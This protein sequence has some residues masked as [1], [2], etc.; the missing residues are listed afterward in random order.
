MYTDYEIRMA[1]AALL[2]MKD[3]TQ[4]R[5]AVLH[6]MG[7]LK[8]ECYTMLR[9]LTDDLKL[10][11]KG[12]DSYSLT[13]EGR[14]AVK[15]GFKAYVEQ[16]DKPQKVENVETSPWYRVSR[17]EIV[18]NTISAVIASIV[19]LLLTWLFRGFEG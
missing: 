1:D 14:R 2:S 19:T 18:Q 6:A 16:H 5:R 11:S 17:R 12:Y 10:V 8:S 4:N 13:F 9:L 3:G 15:M 7:G